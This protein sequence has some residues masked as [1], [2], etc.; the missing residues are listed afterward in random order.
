MSL[1]EE[2]SMLRATAELAWNQLLAVYRPAEVSAAE[3][4][5]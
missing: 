4:E 5:I 2:G 1:D 3:D